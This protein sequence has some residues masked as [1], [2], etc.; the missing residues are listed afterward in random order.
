MKKIKERLV[1]SVIKFMAQENSQ[2]ITPEQQINMGGQLR[3]ARRGGA[4]EGES[5]DGGEQPQSLRQ[6]VMAAR[7]AMDIKQRAKDKVEE[8]V[9]APAKTGTNWLL[10]QA[11]LSIGTVVGFIFIGL[12]YINLHVFGGMVLGEKFFCKLGDEWKPAYKDI[13]GSFGQT[14]KAIGI[15]EVMVLL[16]LD[17]AVG[18]IIASFLGIIVM[19]VTWMDAGAWD[20]AKIIW[21]AGL[22][23]ITALVKLFF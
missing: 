1:L 17:L 11:W 7:K 10:R 12:P 5:K 13:A 3:E 23:G 21:G 6:R 19:I 9:M 16:M 2:T 4:D 22:E 15:I 14:G 20:K 18:C 8:K